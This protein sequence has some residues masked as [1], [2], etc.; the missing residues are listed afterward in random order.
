M[1]SAQVCPKK[2]KYVPKILQRK[3]VRSNERTNE[4][5]THLLLLL[6]M[7]VDAMK[8]GVGRN[9]GSSPAPNSSAR[10]ALLKLPLRYLAPP[11]LPQPALVFPYL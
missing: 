6:L 2:I 7:G 4:K 1:P 3:I 10:S 8:E 9:K 11:R 5:S